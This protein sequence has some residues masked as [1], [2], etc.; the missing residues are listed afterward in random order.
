MVHDIDVIIKLVALPLSVNCLEIP[1][2][3]RR[4]TGE[5]NFVFIYDIHLQEWILVFK[6]VAAFSFK[7]VE[8]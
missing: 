7:H 3:Q 8:S 5:I 1:Y 4:F 2:F 6:W